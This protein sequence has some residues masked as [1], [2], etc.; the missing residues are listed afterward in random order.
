MTE[1]DVRRLPELGRVGVWTNGT[2]WQSPARNAELAVEVEE[3]GYGAVWLSE[4][5]TR[6][7]FLDADTMLRA[8]SRLTL[9]TGIAVLAL[10]Q[11]WAVNTL[12]ARLADAHPD[13]FL[14][15][16]GTSNPALVQDLLGL[17]FDRPL[18]TMRD[19]LTGLDQARA[20]TVAMGLE[21]AAPRQ[22]RVLAALGPKM[23]ALAGSHAEG[24]HSY[25]VP[26]EHTE[27]A[28]RTLGPGPLVVP[29]QAVV[30]STD[31]EV[32]RRR[33]RAHVA[34][35][36]ARPAYPANWIR[37]G[38]TEDDLVD[39]GSDRLVDAVVVGGDAETI[40]ARV[41]AHLDAGADH[42]CIQ[43]LGDDPTA[44]DVD[45]WRALAPALLS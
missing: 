13:R 8:T 6:D 38:F 27:L 42:V 15:G 39:G 4:G 25:L 24:A 31:P 16:L 36:L 5:V 37:L 22:P 10:R 40:R 34:S 41:R 9:A 2:A 14:L 17:P 28:R 45:Q 33:A 32:V 30:L 23:L 11:P 43:A 35:Y 1:H 3:L 18:A 26:P 21:P 20:T 12:T 44:I 29:E 19:Y 7:P